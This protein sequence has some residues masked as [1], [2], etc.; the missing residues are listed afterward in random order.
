MLEDCFCGFIDRK[1]RYVE[2]SIEESLAGVVGS[3]S[4]KEVTESSGCKWC[5]FCLGE[6][7]LIAVDDLGVDFIGVSDDV[8]NFAALSSRRKEPMV[9]VGLSMR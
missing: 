2:L 9:S 1:G 4:S 5:S 6:M 7:P 8:L 3:E